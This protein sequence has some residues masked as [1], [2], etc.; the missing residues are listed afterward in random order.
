MRSEEKKR[1]QYKRL[2]VDIKDDLDFS[3][4]NCDL[5][6]NMNQLFE[7]MGFIYWTTEIQE[8]MI[9]GSFSI[10]MISSGKVTHF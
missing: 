1:V 6:G 8:S 4:K 9:E 2:I 5:C 7:L 3:P 10:R